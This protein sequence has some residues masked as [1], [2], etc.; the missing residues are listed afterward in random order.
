MA[1]HLRR[2]RF[3]DFPESYVVE[4][5]SAPREN[6]WNGR[7]RRHQET[8]MK[9]IDGGDFKI[10]QTDAWHIVGQSA[11]PLFGRDPNPCSSICQGRAVTGSERPFSTCAIEYG[12]ELTELFQRRIATGEVISRDSV[13]RDDKV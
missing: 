2:K 7:Y 3:V 4:F 5:Q 12:F 6:A 1:Q 8:F 10:D 13:K 11:D 9:N